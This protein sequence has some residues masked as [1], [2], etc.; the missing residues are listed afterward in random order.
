[1]DESSDLVR[2][3]ELSLEEDS[4]NPVVI[5]TTNTFSIMVRDESGLCFV[6]EFILGKA[7]TTEEAIKIVYTFNGEQILDF[8]EYSLL[9]EICFEELPKPTYS[10]KLKN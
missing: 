1:M 5:L 8:S 10:I 2:D 3:V 4:V 6:D 7:S 9:P